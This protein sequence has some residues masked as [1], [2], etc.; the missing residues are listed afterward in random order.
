MKIICPDCGLG[1]TADTSRYGKK[2]RCPKCRTVFRVLDE[3]VVSSS[4]GAFEQSIIQ[5]DPMPSQGTPEYDTLDDAPIDGNVGS[6]DTTR[7]ECSRCGFS[8]SKDFLAIIDDLPVCP[9]CAG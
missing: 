7:G 3:V 1:G 2:V 8:F 9:V 6:E 4:T 5:D